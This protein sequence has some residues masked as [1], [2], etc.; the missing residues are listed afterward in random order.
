ME[1]PMG[2]YLPS[3]LHAKLPDGLPRS[4]S[5]MDNT[6]ITN[7]NNNNN[8]TMPKRSHTSSSGGSPVAISCLY[9]S[10]MSDAHV[11]FMEFHKAGC[12]T[13][14]ALSSPCSEVGTPPQGSRLERQEKTRLNL[15]FLGITELCNKISL[16]ATP[17]GGH[18][19]GSTQPPLIGA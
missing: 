17:S 14:Q 2:K 10:P 18:V 7:N 12:F 9:V 13:S 1:Y 15:P 16:T 4:F 6:A 11:F 5:Q 8:N 3:G 19:W